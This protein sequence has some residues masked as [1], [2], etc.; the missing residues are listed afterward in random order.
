MN[1]LIGFLVLILIVVATIIFNKTP[2]RPEKHRKLDKLNSS[3]NQVYLSKLKT[4]NGFY[5]LIYHPEN[6]SCKFK[7]Q[8]RRGRKGFSEDFFENKL[9]VIFKNKIEIITDYC[10]DNNG[11]IYEPDFTIKYSIKGQALL[12]DLEIDEPYE[13]I[14]SIKNRKPIHTV[15]TDNDRNRIFTQNG[16]HVIR[17]T[18]HQIVNMPDES[19]KFIADYIFSFDPDFIVPKAIENIRDIEFEKAWSI[20]DAISWSLD[21]YREKY[22]NIEAF[23]SE[24]SDFSG[25]YECIYVAPDFKDNSVFRKIINIS[26][27][28]NLRVIDKTNKSYQLIVLNENLEKLNKTDAIELIK[29][30]NSWLDKIGLINGKY[31]K[32]ACIN[33]TDELL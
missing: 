8:M 4:K 20:Q 3:P 24:E 28:S 18:E 11:I 15:N 6:T 13:G 16:W 30:D 12:I 31:G 22:L 9:K 10:L 23:P 5:P 26:N 17:F 25:Y 27:Y 1:I 21:L 7:I 14:S 2:T 33:M 19:C 32:Y 29:T